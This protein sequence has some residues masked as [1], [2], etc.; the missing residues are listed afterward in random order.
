MVAAERGYVTGLGQAVRQA[1]QQG[2]QKALKGMNQVGSQVK[3]GLALFP[4][5]E[6]NL[7]PNPTHAQ[8]V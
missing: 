8:S 2:L 3:S 7:H 5:Q 6:Q 1:A 4:H